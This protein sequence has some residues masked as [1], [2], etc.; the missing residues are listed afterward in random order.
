MF[1]VGRANGHD[2][3]RSGRPSV[4]T[5]EFKVRIEKKIQ[6]DKRFTIESYKKNC[7]KCVSRMS[8]EEHK[9]KR[10]GAALTFLG[11]FHKDGDCYW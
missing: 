3:E 6:E 11:R 7:A 10:V 4:V 8:T 5:V 2:E 9:Y 1:N